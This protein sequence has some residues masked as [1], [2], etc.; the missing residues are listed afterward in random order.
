MGKTLAGY[1][2]SWVLKIFPGGRDEGHPR[3]R[4]LCVQ[5]SIACTHE[6]TCHVEGGPPGQDGSRGDMLEGS[7]GADEQNHKGWSQVSA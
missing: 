7:A 6:S 2:W 1:G 3:Q 4:D 5:K